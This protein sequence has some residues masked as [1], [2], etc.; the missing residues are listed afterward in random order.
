MTPCFAEP[1]EHSIPTYIVSALDFDDYNQTLDDATKS[2]ADVNKFKGKF[3]QVLICP[4][5]NGGIERALL[6][7]GSPK[8]RKRVRFCLAAAA[9][10]LPP[11][12]YHIANDFDLPS[13]EYELFGWLM[14]GYRFAKYKEV[15][16][17]NPLLVAPDW[18]DRARVEAMVKAEILCADLINTPTND[19]GPAELEKE[20]ELIA[21]EFSMDFKVIRG[22]KLLSQ[23]FP[24]IHA[25][26][27][28]S[29]SEPRLIELRNGSLGPKICLVGKGVCFDTGGLNLKSGSSMAGMKKD[30][31]GSANVLALTRMIMELGYPCQL[32]V[33]IP[34]VENS[35]SGNAFRPQDILISRKGLSV[36]IN[37]TDAEGRLILADALTYAGEG[38]PDLILS[39]ATLTGAA[40]VAVGQDLAPFFAGTQKNAMALM[41]SSE[42]AKDPVWQLPFWDPYEYLIE[43]GIADLDNAPKGGVGGAITAALFLRR[44]VPDPDRYIHFDIFA[45]NAIATPGRPFGGATQGARAVFHALDELLVH[46]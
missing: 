17:G 2:W 11:A 26:G 45:V 43:P 42:I 30:M 19:M 22:D 40:R 6:G 9:N 8:D 32:Q 15:K 10:K 20:A 13:K 41:T 14:L 24:M 25:V 29:V 5:E 23:N 46:P 31:G 16:A 34:A 28:A 4:D 21:A 27:R 1:S 12:T 36:E 35:V 37:N 7:I 18:A 39:M 38:D 44:F 3:G 33:L